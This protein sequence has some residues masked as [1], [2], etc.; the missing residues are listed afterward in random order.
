MRNNL[1]QNWKSVIFYILIPVMLIGSIFLFSGQNKNKDVKN[2][3]EIVNL[4]RTNQV[5]EYELDLSSGQLTYRLFDDKKDVVNKY[6]VPS[7]TYFIDDIS[8]YVNE[9]ND[10]LL[11]T[12]PSPRDS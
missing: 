9:Y 11:Y 4:F 12:S 5:A 10:C 1:S 8:E 2:Y 7:V 6:T 3:S